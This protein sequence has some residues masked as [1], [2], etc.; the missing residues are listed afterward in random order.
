[1]GCIVNSLFEGL[2]LALNDGIYYYGIGIE[3]TYLL[4]MELP[5]ESNYFHFVMKIHILL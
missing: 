1:M 5:T 3:N 4:I 2:T